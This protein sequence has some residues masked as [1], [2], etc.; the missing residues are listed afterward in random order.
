MEIGKLFE[1][2]VVTEEK[3]KP[4]LWTRVGVAHTNSDGSILVELQA[5]PL[6]GRMLLREPRPFDPGCKK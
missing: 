2:Y 6:S 1:V 5:L 3:G 4:A